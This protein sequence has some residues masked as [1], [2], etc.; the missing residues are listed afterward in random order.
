MVEKSDD[1]TQYL[2]KSIMYPLPKDM[3]VPQT[4]TQYS[5]LVFKDPRVLIQHYRRCR[6]FLHG[7]RGSLWVDNKF[8]LS[9]LPLQ[10]YVLIANL[11]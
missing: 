9:F 7:P 4:L 3:H 8:D 10:K 5:S 6:P 1:I 2:H 11:T